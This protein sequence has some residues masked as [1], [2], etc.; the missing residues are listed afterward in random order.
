MFDSAAALVLD[1]RV[2][3]AAVAAVVAAGLVGVV[4][5]TVTG[6]PGDPA[7]VLARARDLMVE[8]RPEAALKETRR[9]LAMLGRDGDPELHAK[10]LARAAQIADLHMP[11]AHLPEA[12]G[13]YRELIQAHPESDAAFDAGLRLAELLRQRLHDDLHAEEQFVQVVDAFP[14]QAGVERLLL[15][16]GRIALD[17]RRY[18]NA[19]TYAGRLLE[20]YPGSDHAPEAQTLVGQAWRLEGLQKEAAQAFMAVP[21]RWPG[22][23]ASAR[24]LAL[25]GDCLAD[26]GDF[27]HAIARYIESLPR[28]PDP[29]QVQRSL[30]RARRH[31]TAQRDLAPGDKSFAFHGGY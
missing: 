17:N 12:I 25:A 14:H 26:Q 2:R 3:R 16:A 6:R 4:V 10:A 11:D 5:G 19:R 31:F 24:A 1:P 15:R 30:D 9:A 23:E 13:Y 27:G 28:H 22:T 7:E 8:H 21:D 18:R 29:I 20:Q